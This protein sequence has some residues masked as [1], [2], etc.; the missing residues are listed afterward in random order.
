MVALRMFSLL[1]LSLPV[2]QE[3][4]PDSAPAVSVEAAESE[5][6]AAL[7]KR[8]AELGQAKSYAFRMLTISEN[9]GMG[10]GRGGFGGG[11]TR[12]QRGGDATGE[13]RPQRGGGATGEARPQ[14]QGA[15]AAATPAQEPAAPQPWEGVYQAGK[16]VM[17]KRGDLHVA[18]TGERM[19]MKTGEGAWAAMSMPGRGGQGR[20]QG[21][22]QAGAAN[23]DRTQMRAMFEVRTV[24]LPHETLVSILESIDASKLVREEKLGL[25]VFHGPL[26]EEAA[27]RLA[28]GGRSMRGR[29]GRGG[30]DSENQGPIMLGKGMV[31]IAFSPDGKTVDLKID[32]EMGGTMGETEFTASSK[33]EIRAAKIGEATMEIPAAATKALSQDPSLEEEF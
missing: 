21:G 8:V 27:I 22:G 17:M 15:D 30:D 6:M 13:D 14:G 24:Q 2:F 10:G 23:M 16:P 18:K 4:A 25:V 32:A 28:M 11:A 26:T 9:S 31:R 5:T 7:R 33:S 20:G 3:P 12:P 29:G 1:L 19:A